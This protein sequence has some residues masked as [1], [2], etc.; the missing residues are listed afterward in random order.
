MASSSTRNAHW[1]P[2]VDFALFKN[3]VFTGATISNFLIN[4]TAGA[5]TV[6]RPAGAGNT[7]AA[8]AGYLTGHAIFIIAFI[9]GV[10]LLQK[11]GLRKLMIWG[12]LIVLVSISLPRP[13][14]PCRALPI[15][16]PTP[17]GLGLAF[18]ATLH[19]RLSNRLNDQVTW[20]GLQDACSWR[21]F[22]R[23]RLRAIF[24][25]LLTSGPTS[26]VW[27]FVSC[28][29]DNAAVREVASSACFT[30]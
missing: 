16:H 6:S 29:Q 22:R 30:P 20:P 13:P 1:H 18:Y 3:T 7:P 14:T 27:Q 9:R 26:P 17:I 12:T 10:K 23:R 21:R 11:F 25:A 4:G 5:L 15:L 2:F 24:T 28:R 8:E 19:R